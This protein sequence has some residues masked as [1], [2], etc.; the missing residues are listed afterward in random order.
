MPKPCEK[1]LN[2][3]FDRAGA[4]DEAAYLSLTQ[5]L[6]ED[7]LNLAKKMR[8]EGIH[9]GDLVQEGNL[10]LV[11]GR[12][13]LD[14]CRSFNEYK[15]LV[16]KRAEEAVCAFVSEYTAI[17]EKG[18]KIA[19]KLNCLA[20]AWDELNETFGSDFTI[21][22]VSAYSGI[23]IDEIYDLLKVAGEEMEFSSD[24]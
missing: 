6:L 11:S 22:D 2:E 12:D 23:G 3:L 16:L 18:N 14:G 17:K 10:I 9:I 1:E 15:E 8:T 21:E 7:V 24:D 20:E 5:A 13:I 4:A 19:D